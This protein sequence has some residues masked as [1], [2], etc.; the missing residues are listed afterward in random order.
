MEFGSAIS[1]VAIVCGIVAVV[2]LIGGVAKKISE[3]RA[4]VLINTGGK[5]GGTSTQM[6]DALVKIQADIDEMKA[7]L[8]TIV[9]QLDNLK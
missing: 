3:H 5:K 6:R 4:E 8:N 9:I 7:D 2:A 1:I